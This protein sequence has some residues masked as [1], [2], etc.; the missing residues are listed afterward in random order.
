ML[1]HHVSGGCVA[2][3]NRV[4]GIRAGNVR[5]RC[6]AGP[7]QL[8]TGPLHSFDKLFKPSGVIRQRCPTIMDSEIEVDHVPLAVAQPYVNLI[9]PVRR[10]TADGWSSMNIGDSCKFFS[11]RLRVGA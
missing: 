3:S 1:L 8:R 10:W 5:N 9:Q 6:C 2:W 4:G 11:D 7:N